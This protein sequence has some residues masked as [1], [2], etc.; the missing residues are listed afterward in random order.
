V[1]LR[2]RSSLPDGKRFEKKQGT[3]TPTMAKA[4]ARAKK[5]AVKKKKT[6]K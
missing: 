4:K 2:Q 1:T 3:T 5:P 6:A